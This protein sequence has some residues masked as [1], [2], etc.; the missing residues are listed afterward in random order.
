MEKKKNISTKFSDFIKKQ[1]KLDVKKLTSNLISF[2]K[3]EAKETRIAAKIVA[4]II[5]NYFKV[6]KDVVTEKEI[7]FLKEHSVDLAKI[8]PIIASLPTPIPY[9]QIALILKKFGVDILPTEKD[10]EIPDN[11]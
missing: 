8:I 3:R 9:F 1:G 11:H 5:G 7:K 10:L 2:T 4:K 6:D